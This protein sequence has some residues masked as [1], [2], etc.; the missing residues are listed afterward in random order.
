M[1][2]Q[3]HINQIF[4]AVS[5]RLKM[6]K[7]GLNDMSK[8][9]RLKS[10]LWNAAIFGR[11]ATLALQ[12]LRGKVPDFDGWYL[13]KQEAMRAD[14]LMRYFVKLRNEIEKEASD[15]Q[16]SAR[17]HIKS[18]SDSDI[19]RLGPRPPNATSFFIGDNVGGSGWE[20][21]LPDGEV[22]KFYVELP[23]DIGSTSVHLLDAPQ[24]AEKSAAELVGSYIGK[25]EAL[26][27]EARQRFT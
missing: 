12:N 7:A 3:A 6:A 17:T 8:P 2:E 10:G 23:P 1:T 18:F 5:D 20:V 15:N 9:E 21:K 26:V 4:A 25:L 11:S 22:E 16:L 24:G 14:P 19:A 27:T 13:P